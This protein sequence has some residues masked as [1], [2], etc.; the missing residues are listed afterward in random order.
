[1]LTWYMYA[2]IMRG[3]VDTMPVKLNLNAFISLKL[4]DVDGTI[5]LSVAKTKV[6]ARHR[7]M[8]QSTPNSDEKRRALAL[9]GIDIGNKIAYEYITPQKIFPV[10]CSSYKIAGKS[11]FAIYIS[12]ILGICCLTNTMYENVN[13]IRHT[14][15]R[16]DVTL[17]MRGP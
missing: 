5:V 16:I 8:E 11:S 3:T 6:T 17:A 4:W 10:H 12:K 1:M 13:P 9:R 2:K 15:L 14:R 7:Y